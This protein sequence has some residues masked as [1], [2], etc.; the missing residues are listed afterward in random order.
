MKIGIV[1]AGEQ[2]VLHAEHYF[3]LGEK[4]TAVA[5]VNTEKVG[6]LAHRFAA[7]PY[8]NYEKMLEEES[9][10][11]VSICTPP[12]YKPEIVSRACE[13]R[14]NIVCEIPMANSLEECDGMIHQASSAN[15]KLMITNQFRHLANTVKI[16]QMINS[17]A[18]GKVTLFSL[19][20]VSPTRA[21]PWVEEGGGPLEYIAYWLDLARWYMGE[22]VELFAKR[23]IQ[24]ISEKVP[25]TIASTIWF[26]NGGLAQINSVYGVS[27][28]EITLGVLFEDNTY[29]YLDRWRLDDVELRIELRSSRTNTVIVVCPNGTVNKTCY[30]SAPMGYRI[31]EFKHYINCAKGNTMPLTPGICGRKVQELWLGI[32]KSTRTNTIVKLPL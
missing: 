4:V 2:G 23:G 7:E 20:L 18:H 30:G 17:G 27:S 22:A 10:D 32:L 3:A 1:G 12:K 19:T 16:K 6:A 25:D 26:A 31:D 15:I 14:C 24:R 9:L 21:K 13:A 28:V 5:D 29:V 11:L 8:E